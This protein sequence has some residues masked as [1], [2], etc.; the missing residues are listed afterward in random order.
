MKDIEAI[1]AGID[2]IKIRKNVS[3]KKL[4]T[5][6]LGGDI[7][8]LVEPQTVMAARTLVRKFNEEQIDYKI[9]GN[10]SN[11]IISDNGISKPIIIL[12]KTFNNINLY[13]DNFDIYSN[14]KPISNF[15]K[16]VNSMQNIKVF[17][18]AAHSLMKLSRITSA[19]GYTGLEFAAGIPANVGGAV[20]MNAGAHGSST[21][22]N[23]SS[24]FSINIHGEVLE[25]SPDEI[26]FTYRRSGLDERNL[27]IGAVFDFYFKGNEVTLVNKNK[28]LAYRQET[29][30]LSLPSSG[31]VFKNPSPNTLRNCKLNERLTA[32]ELLDELDLKG[33]TRGGIQFSTLHAN[34]L[35]KIS[36]S[37]KVEDLVYL[38]NLAK[39]KVANRFNITLETEIKIWQN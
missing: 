28:S 14:I 12:G 39:E 31:S 4:T 6:A 24:I 20:F 5:F 15:E 3:A 23:V 10:G 18:F 35:V 11:V 8:Y 19:A 17:A 37:A 38:V 32:A 13:D 21:L 34:W 1:I 16:A 25:Q 26:N 2:D 22:E 7:S 27:V 33:L 29:Q 9:L 30:P 36:D